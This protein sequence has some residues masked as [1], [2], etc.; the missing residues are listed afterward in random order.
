MATLTAEQITALATGVKVLVDT[1]LTTDEVGEFVKDACV[2]VDELLTGV[3]YSENRLS[4]I[5]K[6]LAAHNLCVAEPRAKK[7]DIDKTLYEIE[8]KA[9]MGLARTRFGQ[10]VLRLD[11][12]GIL[13][14][15]DVGNKK[16]SLRG[17]F[18]IF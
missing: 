15:T 7:E 3:G 13:A 1:N 6:N 2:E 11:Y 4:L 9:D 12:K 16:K 14:E 8:G 10:Q 18:R 17:I 5:T